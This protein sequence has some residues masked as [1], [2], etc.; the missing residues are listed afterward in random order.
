MIRMEVPKGGDRI[1]VGPPLGRLLGE[2]LPCR[3]RAPPRG[4]PACSCRS[5]SAAR[6]RGADEADLILHHG[7]VV[8]V[9]RDFSV[10]QALAVKGDRLLR[11][12]TDEEVLETRGPRHGD[13]RPRRQDGPARA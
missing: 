1:G 8:T 4:L 3:R 2:P 11:V 6:P 12:G 9:D 13:G 5:A 10:R 7:K